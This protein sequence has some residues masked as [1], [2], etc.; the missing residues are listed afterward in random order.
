[1]PEPNTNVAKSSLS[2]GPADSEKTL[3]SLLP[4]V[5]ILIIKFAM[6]SDSDGAFV[7]DC[8][9]GRDFKPNVA[10]QLLRVK[11]V[12]KLAF[13]GSLL[14]QSAQAMRFITKP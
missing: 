12:I 6:K 14:T 13:L 8:G 5:W 7:F 1:M 2:S 10:T 4:E 11:Y 9:T 3:P